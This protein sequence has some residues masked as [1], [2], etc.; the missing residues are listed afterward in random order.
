MLK[1][2]LDAYMGHQNTCVVLAPHQLALFPLLLLLV[3][4][5]TPALLRLLTLLRLTGPAAAILNLKQQTN[6][7][8]P[9]LICCGS[10]FGTAE[11]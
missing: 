6:R 8:T 1:L 2:L 5:P 3:F 9:V 4:T 11:E 7:S 10:V